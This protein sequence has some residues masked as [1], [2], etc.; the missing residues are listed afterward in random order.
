MRRGRGKRE[1]PLGCGAETYILGVSEFPF[2][3]NFYLQ[4]SKRKQN[5]IIIIIVN[6]INN[7]LN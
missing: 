6:K 1:D 7:K 5:K 4:K 2:N 3:S